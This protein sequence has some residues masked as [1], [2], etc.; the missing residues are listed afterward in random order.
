MH[1]N[2]VVCMKLYFWY[3]M[4]F[5]SSI[6]GYFT[7]LCKS[8]VKTTLIS[9]YKINVHYIIDVSVLQ[10]QGTCKR[11]VLGI[12]SLLLLYNWSLIFTFITYCVSWLLVGRGGSSNFSLTGLWSTS[13]L[14]SLTSWFMVALVTKDW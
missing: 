13:F 3:N 5:I 4:K 6:I 9:C 2:L 12:L 14:S 10:V 1:N 11:E 8:Q 7:M